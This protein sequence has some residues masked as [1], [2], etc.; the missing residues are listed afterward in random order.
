L[1]DSG[2]CPWCQTI[3][4]I[5][6]YGR[7]R[8]QICGKPIFVT[9]DR[10]S[11]SDELRTTNTKNEHELRTTIIQAHVDYW[12]DVLNELLAMEAELEALGLGPRRMI[13]EVTH[14]LK[15]LTTPA[16]G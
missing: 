13:A 9:R 4:T 12:N 14:R 10:D 15:R 3:Q 1:I 7:Q 11:C 6:F 16:S 5:T 8:C 2:I